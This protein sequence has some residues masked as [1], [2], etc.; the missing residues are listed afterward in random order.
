MYWLYSAGGFTSLSAL[1]AAIIT[2][3]LILLF[4]RCPGKPYL[5]GAVTVIGGV[6]ASMTWGMRV[7]MITFLM[8][9]AFLLILERFAE[10]RNRLIWIL[11][12][13]M[14]LW[15]NLHGGYAAGLAIVG[16]FLAG[17]VLDAAIGENDRIAAMRKVRVLAI[18]LL[19]CVLAVGL[20]PNG[21]NLYS[22]P[23]ETV[24]LKVTDYIQEWQSPNF[25]EPL[26][27]AWYVGVIAA[28]AASPMR[29]KLRD[30]VPLLAFAYLSLYSMRHVPLFVVAAAPVLCEHT[31]AIIRRRFGTT[32]WERPSQARGGLRL[33]LNLLILI[34]VPLA[35]VLRIESVAQRRPAKIR[36]DFP[37]EAVEFI[38]KSRPPAPL[39]NH[40][41]A[42]GYVVWTLYPE[43]HVY[44][45]GRG[46]MY[47]DTFTEECFRL[48]RGLID[49]VAVLERRGV[50][51]ALVMRES[52]IN[53]ILS[54]ATGW[55]R[56][57]HDKDWVVF[58]R[59]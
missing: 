13:L 38:R 9:S 7:Q 2:L 53:P 22:Y 49:P 31:L 45:D 32:W 6:A 50:R 33:A 57:H 17:S 14:V 34:F 8:A 59:G 24:R 5:A 19:L 30:L 55:R 26:L 36:E 35:T 11:V 10:G 47:S 54:R 3:A 56:V 40:Y 29:M 27:L 51:T 18:V 58:V 48:E 1:Y 28:I 21:I 44:V 41:G 4:L 16:L 15:A 52:P 43:Y 23:F 20:T 37:V 42:G 39:F 46:D 12:P 25:H